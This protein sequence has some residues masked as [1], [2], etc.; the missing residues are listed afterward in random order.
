MAKQGEGATTLKMKANVD[1]LVAT[2]GDDMM[3]HRMGV[4]RLLWDANIK[5]EFNQQENPKLKYEIASALEQGI[6]YMVIVG[7]E[8]AANGTCKLKSL[9]DRT[10]ETV[11]LTDLVRVLKRDKGV[12]P[13]GCEF[14]AELMASEQQDA[15]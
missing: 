6:P 14:A 8:E 7:S 1:V 12:V 5:A 10:E 9:L 4:A 13:V 11:V 3:V 2:V 15:K